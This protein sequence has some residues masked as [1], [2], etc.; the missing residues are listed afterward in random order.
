M[1]G[2][3]YRFSTWFDRFIM[4]CIMLNVLLMA[5]EHHGQPKAWS[6]L[7]LAVNVWFALIFSGEFFLKLAGLGPSKY[8]SD[9]SNLFDC[10][11]TI[12]SVAELFLS[13]KGPYTV[14]RAFR[15]FRAMR[16]LRM[17]KFL[18]GLL[19]QVRILW[20]VMSEMG[21]FLLLMALLVLT[22]AIIGMHLVGGKFPSS[23]KQLQLLARERNQSISAHHA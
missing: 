12:M 14:M 1:T 19:Q 10:F 4:T 8:F 5:T 18:P 6:D 16:I 21:N 22:Y 11:V 3:R 15:A 20:A 9:S 17:I 13:G 23:A 2:A 7:Q